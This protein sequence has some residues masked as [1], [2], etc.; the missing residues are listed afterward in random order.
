MDKLEN[1]VDLRSAASSVDMTPS[2][3]AA[4]AASAPKSPVLCHCHHHH[5]MAVGLELRSSRLAKSNR[6]SEDWRQ[7]FGETKT[8]KSAPS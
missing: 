4:M 7:F 5:Q 3:K 2:E 1:M 8:Q 6:N